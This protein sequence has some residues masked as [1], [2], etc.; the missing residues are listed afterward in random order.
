MPDNNDQ[1]STILTKA[2][3][4]L[5][6][7]IDE[8]VILRVTTVIGTVT[9]ENA[10]DPS[11]QT[12]ITVD[13]ANQL[14]AHTAINTALGDADIVMSKGF[15]DDDALNKLHTQALADS[16]AIRKDSMDLLHSAIQTLLSHT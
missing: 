7:I 15:I 1:T 3:D 16:R 14:V 12:K 6:K 4:A 5:G 11:Q 10:G 13:P 2:Y 9:V 8:I